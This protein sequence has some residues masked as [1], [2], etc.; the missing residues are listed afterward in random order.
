MKCT[1]F[2]RVCRPSLLA[3]ISLSFPEVAAMKSTIRIPINDRYIMISNVSRFPANSRPAI[4]MSVKLNIAPS[5][6]KAAL[7]G[8]DVCCLIVFHQ[9][10]EHNLR[11]NLLSFLGDAF[12]GIS[13]PRIHNLNGDIDF[14]YVDKSNFNGFIFITLV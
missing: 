2:R 10:K 14:T 13:T 1:A 6:T 9:L 4:A 3:L 11:K 12:G 8:C 7:I 5:M